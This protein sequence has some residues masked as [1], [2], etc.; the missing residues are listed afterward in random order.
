[1][2]P[3][4]SRAPDPQFPPTIESRFEKSIISKFCPEWEWKKYL[5]PV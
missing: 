3:D 1:M 4:S 2:I 5:N